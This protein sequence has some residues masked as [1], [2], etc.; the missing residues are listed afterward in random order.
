MSREREPS[1]TPSRNIPPWLKRAGIFVLA[2]LLAF[3]LGLIPMWLTARERGRE[4]NEAQRQLRLTQAQLNLAAAA[5]DARRGEYEP[6]R[7]AT[8][9]FF[10]FLRQQTTGEGD[11]LLTQ[12]QRQRLQPLL[13]QR[14]DLITLLARNDPASAERLSELHVAFRQVAANP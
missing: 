3:L 13:A 6:A 11:A 12:A 10:D 7:V 4:L 2:L 1:P 8:S 9:N 5:L 14:D